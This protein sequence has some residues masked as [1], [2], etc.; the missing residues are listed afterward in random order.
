MFGVKKTEIW[1]FRERRG[2]NV[3]E[4]IVLILFLL[5]IFINRFFPQIKPSL[6]RHEASLFRYEAS[7]KKARIWVKMREFRDFLTNE[8]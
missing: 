8:Q 1:G 6:P 2:N 5:I 4:Y 3:F 7:Y